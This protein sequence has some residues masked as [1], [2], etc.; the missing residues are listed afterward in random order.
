VDRDDEHEREDDPVDVVEDATGQ[1]LHVRP[2]R[3]LLDDYPNSIR[4]SF[5]KILDRASSCRRYFCNCRS[6]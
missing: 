3:S 2:P 6:V 1:E 5:C 4:T